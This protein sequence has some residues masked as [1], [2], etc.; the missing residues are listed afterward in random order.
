MKIE[1]FRN[2]FY[3]KFY[4]YPI[5]DSAKMLCKLLDQKTLT[6]DNIQILKEFKCEIVIKNA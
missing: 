5:N 3:G 4:Y 6:E 1:I 2:N